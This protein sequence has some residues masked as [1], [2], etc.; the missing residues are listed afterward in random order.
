M[1][2]ENRVLKPVQGQETIRE[3]GKTTPI[4][5]KTWT[6]DRDIKGRTPVN[7]LT[8]LAINTVYFKQ[9]IYARL[10]PQDGQPRLLHL[11]TDKDEMLTRHLQ[12]EQEVTVRKRGSA[13]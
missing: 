13:G 1:C 5:F 8:G 10:N 6:P 4:P 11:P 7:A 12:S 2:A 3:P 9:I